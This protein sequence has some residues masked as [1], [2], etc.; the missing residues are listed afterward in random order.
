MGCY[1]WSD[2][3]TDSGKNNN[4]GGLDY[5]QWGYSFLFAFPVIIINF[6]LK[7]IPDKIVPKVLFLI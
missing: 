5:L 1:K 3:F 2:N 4:K 7:L 6:I